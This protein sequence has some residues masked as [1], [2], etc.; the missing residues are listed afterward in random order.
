MAVGGDLGTERLMRAYRSGIFPW[1]NDD[2]LIL[3]WSPDPRTVLFPDKL[4][5]SKSLRQELRKERFKVTR[6]RN[7]SEV[8]AQCAR[9]RRKGQQGTWITERM[10]QA[11]EELHKLGYAISYEVWEENKLV[12]G[13]Y[14]IDLGHVFCGESMFSSVSNASKVGFVHMVR[15]LAGNNYRCLDC[16]VYSDHLASLGAEE[17]S[18]GKFLELLRP[19]E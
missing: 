19:D 8:I 15:E 1:F 13:L 11:Y 3:W 10:L 2:S 5:V 4:K 18:R 9:V 12:G 16:Q 14:G 6:N 17:I 7:F